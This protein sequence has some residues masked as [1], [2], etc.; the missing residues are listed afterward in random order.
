MAGETECVRLLVGAGA[1]LNVQEGDG[2]TSLHCASNE[3]KTECVKMLIGAGAD[4][5]ICATK[6]CGGHKAG[7]RAI[8]VAREMGHTKIVRLLSSSE[9][10]DVE[11]NNS[12]CVVV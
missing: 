2:W 10:A 5:S 9:E 12:T 11:G 1:D 6:Q 4:K 7:S 3:G 8:D